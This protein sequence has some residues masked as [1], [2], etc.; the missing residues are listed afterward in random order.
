MMIFGPQHP[1]VDEHFIFL[2]IAIPGI[3][4]YIYIMFRQTAITYRFVAA[5]GLKLIILLDDVFLG[6]Y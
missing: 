5:R 3:Y 2:K 4:I 1:M 6:I